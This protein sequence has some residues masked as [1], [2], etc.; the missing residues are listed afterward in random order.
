MQLTILYVLL[1]VTSVITLPCDCDSEEVGVAV[2]EGFVM[3][4]MA[5]G[6][7]ENSNEETKVSRMLL[8]DE[9]QCSDSDADLTRLA[10][11]AGTKA[12]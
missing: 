12:K 3:T 2:G 9:R 8:L 10:P 1:N 4:A 5:A 7:K 11:L 6:L